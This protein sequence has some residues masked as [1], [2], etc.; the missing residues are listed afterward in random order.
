MSVFKAGTTVLLM[1][2]LRVLPTTTAV[3]GTISKEKVK[4]KLITLN[5]F[6]VCQFN[7]STVF[8]KLDNH[9]AC[10]DEYRP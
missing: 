6:I 4:Y 5:T 3:V 10:K 7:P 9:A 8:A 1:I 2:V